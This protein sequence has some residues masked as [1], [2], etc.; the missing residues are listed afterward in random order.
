MQLTQRQ[1]DKAN[2][3]TISADIFVY[4]ISMPPLIQFWYC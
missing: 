2:C 1:Q 3:K 4:S